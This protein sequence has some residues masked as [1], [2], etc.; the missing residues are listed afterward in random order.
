[1]A[2]WICGAGS[3]GRGVS[4]LRG[5]GGMAGSRGGGGGG[6]LAHAGLPDVGGVERQRPVAVDLFWGRSGVRW[7]LAGGGKQLAPR[8]APPL[9]SPSGGHRHF[10]RAR[11]DL[12]GTRKASALAWKRGSLGGGREG[13]PAPVAGGRAGQGVPAGAVALPN[14]H[15]GLDEGGDADAGED[16]ADEVADGELVLAHAQALGQQ[17]GDGDGAAEARQ[18]VLGGDGVGSAGPGCCGVPH[19]AGSGGSGSAD[20]G[21]P[22]PPPSRRYLE[23]EQDAEVPG[24]HILD[25]VEHVHRRPRR[26]GAHPGLLAWRGTAQPRLPRG[27]GA[28]WRHH[29]WHRLPHGTLCARGGGEGSRLAGLHWG[30]C[31]RTHRAR[32]RQ[33]L[34]GGRRGAGGG[35]RHTPVLAA[36]A[37][38][39]GVSAGAGVPWAQSWA[40]PPRCESAGRRRRGWCGWSPPPGAASGHPEVLGWSPRGGWSPGEGGGKSPL[41]PGPPRGGQEGRLSQS[42]PQHPSA[43]P[44]RPPSPPS[45]AHPIARHE[46]AVTGVS[47]PGHGHPPATPLPCGREGTGLGTGM[48][49][50]FTWGCARSPERVPILRQRGPGGDVTVQGVLWT[51]EGL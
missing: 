22:P 10:S 45:P 40:L 32:R 44:R 4:G 8:P 34:P 6:Y 23:A 25:L 37:G 51:G 31:P 15:G 47:N 36:R 12:A 33:L 26:P 49:A 28:G 20:G 43:S 21:T 39:S 13:T 3:E 7:S 11:M 48:E 50:A 9:P 1:M 41:V 5:G 38:G 2:P 16:G 24:G 29:G 17:E 18:V 19:T 42:E 46:L 27:A 14:A 35:E 30:G